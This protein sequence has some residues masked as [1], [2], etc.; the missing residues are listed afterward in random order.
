MLR[1]PTIVIS[2]SD[3]RDHEQV[4]WDWVRLI[5]P[6]H[7]SPAHV[8]QAI[9]PLGPGPRCRGA[10]TF[11]RRRHRPRSSRRWPAALRTP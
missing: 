3:H 1:I 4:S 10:E 2:D 5:P 8:D 6:S 11:W 7:L 9:K